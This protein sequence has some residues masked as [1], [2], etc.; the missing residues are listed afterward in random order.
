GGAAQGGAAQGGAAQGG[1]AQGGAQG[2]EEGGGAWPHRRS[3]ALTLSLHAPEA[4]Q[5]LLAGSFTGWGDAPLPLARDAE[6]RFSLTLSA[7]EGEGARLGLREGA[8]YPYKLIVDGAWR[9]HG[10]AAL[11]M[12][13]GSCVNSALALPDCE[14]PDLER[15]DLRVSWRPEAS[16][17]GG[18]VG[19]GLVTLRLLRGASGAPLAALRASLDGEPVSVA[20]DPARGEATVAL[21]DLAR[22]KRWLTLTAEDAA[23]RRSEERRW[24]LWVEPAPFDWEGTPLYMVLVDRFANG[25]P[26]RD[27]PTGAPVAPIADWRGGDLQGVTRALEEGYFERLGVRALWLSPLNAQVDG[28][29]EDRG[30]AG[31]RFSAYHGYWPVRG[32]EVDARYGGAEGL[33]ALV[34]AAHA[35][36]VRVLLD[37]INNQVHEEHEYVA[38]HPEWFR[39]SCVCGAEAGCGWSE[40]PLDCLFAPYLPDINWRDP[41]AEEQ[42]IRDALYWVDEFGVDGFRVDAVKHVETTSIYNLRDAL[43]RRFE[44]GGAR[45]WMLG[46]TAV[47]EGDRADDGCGVRY[48]SGYEWIEA[49]TGPRALDGQF[50]FPTHHRVRWQLLSGAGSFE[51][52]EAALADAERRYAPTATHVRFLGSHDTPRVASEA[53]GDLAGACL[54]DDEQGC[55]GRPPAVEDPEALDRLA[56]AWALLYLTPGTPLLYYGD[57]LALPGAADP[58]NRRPMPW[59]GALSALAIDGA[60]PSAPQEGLRGWLEALA[61]LRATPAARGRRAPLWVSRDSYMF[62]RVS[63]RGEGLLVALNQGRAEVSLSAPLPPEWAGRDETLPRALTRH[64]ALAG[65]GARL[66][67]GLV[68]LTLAPGEAAVFV[69][70]P[71]APRP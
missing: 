40:R 66:S 64:P 12:F 10:D 50:D 18:G 44:G 26:S 55:A 3:C 24:P 63:A 2:G 49:Y 23:G 67:G 25:D 19:D 20:L 54:W 51:A 15:V 47:G 61:A 36:G 38:S 57:E 52:V 58:D 70:A 4:R 16:A 11:Q 46:E 21:R 43:A 6:G 56:R 41:G 34:R 28:H 62:A 45:V 31:R 59:G 35:R 71:R 14:A 22:G 13:E 37:L 32:R 7:R 29:F 9:L 69:S 5:V 48:A 33:R 17:P 60:A 42:F 39:A 30:G 1:A 8:R 27:A 68:T 53:A 65:A